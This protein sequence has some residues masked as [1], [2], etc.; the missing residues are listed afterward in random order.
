MSDIQ[1]TSGAAAQGILKDTAGAQLIT[2]TLDKMNTFQTLGGP[3]I[4]TG[5]QLR[6]DVLNAAGIGMKLNTVA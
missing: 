2:K 3:K 4:D 5:Y 1:S 6:K